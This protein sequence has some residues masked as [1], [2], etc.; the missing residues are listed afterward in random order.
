MIFYKRYSGD[1]LRDTQTLTLME[2]GAYCLMLDYHYSDSKPIPK[3]DDLYRLLRCHSR[4]EKNAADRIIRLFWIETPDGYINA[5][6]QKEMAQAAE[7][8]EKNRLNGKRGGRP[9]NNPN[10]TQWVN[11]GFVENNPNHNPNH[12][13][14]KRQ[15]EARNQKPDLTA[16]S[17]AEKYPNTGGFIDVA[18]G[19]FMCEGANN[20][21]T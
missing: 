6:A 14:K 5:K 8:A 13:P 3:G 12:N 11:S 9:R 4:A 21:N 18:T 20:E 1:Y 15:P 17:Q 16:P 10:K 7:S 2:H 19:E